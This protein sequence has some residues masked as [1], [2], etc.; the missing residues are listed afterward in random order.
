MRA[1]DRA[2]AL[3]KARLR[4]IGHSM[5]LEAQSVSADDEKEQL[6]IMV[7]KIIE[8]AGSSLWVDDL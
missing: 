6:E 2:Q 7:R 3:A 1:D 5:A 8:K 4:T